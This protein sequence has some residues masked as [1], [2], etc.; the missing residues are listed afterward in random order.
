MYQFVR[1]HVKQNIISS[2]IEVPEKI[3]FPKICSLFKL[4]LKGEE[5]QGYDSCKGMSLTLRR[6]IFWYSCLNSNHSETPD[7]LD[8][9]A[10][11]LVNDTI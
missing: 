9:N 5:M 11:A 10:C 3:I 6:L 2:Q 7:V 8:L 4:M 1:S